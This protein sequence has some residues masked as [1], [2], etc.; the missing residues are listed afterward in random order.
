[1]PTASARDEWELAPVMSTTLSL[2]I[3]VLGASGDLAKK[4]TYPALFALYQKGF[5]PPKLQIVGYARSALTHSALRDRLR[6]FLKAEAATDVDAFL[7]LCTYEHGEYDQDEGYQALGKKVMA[8]EADHPCNMTP[9]VGRLYYLALPPAVYPEV[10]AGLKRNMGS[11][12]T[13]PSPHSWIRI[14]LEKPFGRDLESSEELA[15]GIGRLWPEDNLYRI[16]HYLGKELVQNLLQLDKPPISCKQLTDQPSYTSLTYAYLTKAVL[17]LVLVLQVLRFGNTLF[18]AWWNRHY[19]ANVQITFK[20]PFGTDGRGGYFD[21]YGIIRDVI[22]NHLIQVFALLAMEP[23]VSLHP[24]DIRDEKPTAS[25]ATWRTPTVPKGSRTPT[26]A[27]VRLGIKNERWAGV[28]FI[29]KAGKALNERTALYPDRYQDVTIPDAYERLILDCIRGGQ[30]WR[31]TG[32][33]SLALA[34]K[35]RLAATPPG[36]HL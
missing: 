19:V 9:L 17:V 32:R 18:S 23:P 29:I 31:Q 27:A 28:P 14:I 2:T 26:F 3:V 21:Q 30:T 6:P 16:D 35:D 11:I 8:W 10:C 7:A 12:G 24:D 15:E 4:K 22:Q 13:H 34:A 5:L 1:M 36:F 25:L 33:A 20:E